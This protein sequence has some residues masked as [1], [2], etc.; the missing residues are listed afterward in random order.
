[1][2]EEKSEAFDCVFNWWS[3]FAGKETCE[4]GYLTCKEEDC[5]MYHKEKD[6]GK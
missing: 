3:G 2:S 4:A 5:P 6:D 1:M